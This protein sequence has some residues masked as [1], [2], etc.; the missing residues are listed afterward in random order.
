M[1]AASF[2]QACEI[3]DWSNMPRI[4]GLKTI[5]IIAIRVSQKEVS[6]QLTISVIL[7]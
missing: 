1:F 2:S 7:Y 5:I 6:F 4:V 3:F